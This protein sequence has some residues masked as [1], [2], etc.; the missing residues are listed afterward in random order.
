MADSFQA[1]KVTTLHNITHRSLEEMEYDLLH[2]S[3][4]RP[5]GLILPALYS[6]LERPAL[7]NI[8]QELKQVN[9]LKQIVIGLDRADEAQYR[10]AL[11]YFSELPQDYQILWNDGENL[12]AIDRMLQEEGLAPTEL[13]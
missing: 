3:N 12:R 5:M 9:Y 13:G 1:G 8:V 10:H 11:E 4:F 7:A 6:E 2:F